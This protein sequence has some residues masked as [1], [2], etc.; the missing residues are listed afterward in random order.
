MAAKDP[1]CGMDV[2]HKH[3]WEYKGIHYCFCS[4]ECEDKFKENPENFI[5]KEE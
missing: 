1:V 3:C 2:E 5:K 4:G